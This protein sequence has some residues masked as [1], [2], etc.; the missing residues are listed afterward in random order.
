[1]R[2]STGSLMNKFAGKECPVTLNVRATIKAPA[3]HALS[4][5]VAL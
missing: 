1:M 2:G 3:D 5:R 4:L